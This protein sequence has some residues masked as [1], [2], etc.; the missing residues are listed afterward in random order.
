MKDSRARDAVRDG[1]HAVRGVFEYVKKER[2]EQEQKEEQRRRDE[3]HRQGSRLGKQEH[4]GHV[5]EKKEIALTV[6]CMQGTHR[7]VSIAERIAKDLRKERI[8]VKV[9]HIHRETMPKDDF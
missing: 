7:S 4:R 6:C 5:H 3:I 1:V 9:K 2:R 8:K